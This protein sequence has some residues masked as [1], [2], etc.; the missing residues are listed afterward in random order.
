[1][2]PVA[3]Y[4]VNRQRECAS[5][6]PC[7]HRWSREITNKAEFTCQSS[8]TT[9]YFTLLGL[10]F[11]YFLWDPDDLRR[12]VETGAECLGERESPCSS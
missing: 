9:V 2:K 5:L 12:H 6:S 3:V 10:T 1:M 11:S 8:F 7:A 4:K